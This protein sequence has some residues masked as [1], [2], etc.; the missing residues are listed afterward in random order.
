M[1][2]NKNM[3]DVKKDLEVFAIFAL[4]LAVI[5]YFIMVL[6]VFNQFGLL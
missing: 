1:F 5:V 2:D 6:R 3:K 4:C